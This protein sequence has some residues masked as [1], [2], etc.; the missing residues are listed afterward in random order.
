MKKFSIVLLAILASC[1]LFTYLIYFDGE[2]ENIKKWWLKFAASSPSLPYSPYKHR[3]VNASELE[4]YD[5]NHIEFSDAHLFW[6][7]SGAIAV[8]LLDERG[9]VEKVHVVSEGSGYS[10]LVTG[11]VVGCNEEKF[12]IGQLR[13]NR[14]SIKGM[15]VLKSYRW[16]HSP[17]YFAQ[18]E[19]L[20]FSGTAE[21]KF[22]SGQIIEEVPYLDGLVHGKVIRFNEYGI[23]KY[24]KE[25][26]KGEKHGTHIYWFPDPLD[27]ENY[28]PEN[29]P[30]GGKFIT[31]WSKVRYL[32]TKK[33]GQN[34]GSHSSN[35]WMVEKYR[36]SG[37]DFRVKLLEHWSKNLKHGLF[38]G[39]DQ[40]GNKTF[41][42]EYQM[43][44][45]IKHKT[46]DKTK[47]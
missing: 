6:K 45:R 28:E 34:F 26:L 9:F 4:V 7:G 44:R 33:F 35:K 15:T 22:P 46:F 13:T 2:K 39:F 47:G 20:P 5:A 25:Y 24:S 3:R 32:A 17:L 42:D 41:K 12:V 27:P 10:N 36:L 11:K 21:T 43:G 37:G 16:S 31:L 40:F 30:E 38:E 23:P 8:P 19:D 18:G 14:G 1:S 29:S